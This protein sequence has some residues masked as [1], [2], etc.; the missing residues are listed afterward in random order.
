MPVVDDGDQNAKDEIMQ[1]FD[2][3]N[4][5]GKDSMDEQDDHQ[6]ERFA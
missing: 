2:N 5:S 1:G 3:L 6:V 4:E